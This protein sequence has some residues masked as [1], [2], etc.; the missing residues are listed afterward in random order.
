MH[1]N[2]ATDSFFFH[3]IAEDSSPSVLRGRGEKEEGRKNTP[4]FTDAHE[5]L[6]DRDNND[7]DTDHN[8][9]NEDEDKGY[10][11]LR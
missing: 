6:M 1:W 11:V 2:K 10:I 5:E 8:A 4:N 7:R 3:F 9:E